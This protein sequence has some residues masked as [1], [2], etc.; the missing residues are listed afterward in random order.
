MGRHDYD[1]KSHIHAD[2]PGEEG[3]V[4]LKA[5]CS[6]LFWLSDY[7]LLYHTMAR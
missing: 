4:L 6:M 2:K 7:F 1:G 5:V 3:G